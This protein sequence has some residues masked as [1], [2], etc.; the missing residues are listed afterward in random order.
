MNFRILMLGNGHAKTKGLL[1]SIPFLNRYDATLL[2]R[3]YERKQKV[4]DGRYV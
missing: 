1:C 2:A 3:V 4:I